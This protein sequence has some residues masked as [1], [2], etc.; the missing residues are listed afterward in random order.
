MK[1]NL[2]LF[3]HDVLENIALIENSTKRSKKDFESD[4]DIIDATVRRL[5]IIGEAV[6]NIPTS[7]REKHPQVPWKGV[8]GFRD[9][10]THGYFRVDLNLVW[11]IVQED[12]PGLKKQIQKVKEELDNK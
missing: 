6:K 7:F 11:K 2:E 1:R 4:K 8:T 3:L 12:L 10:L 5:E 9:V